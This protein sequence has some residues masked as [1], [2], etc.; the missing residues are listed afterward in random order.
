M[1]KAHSLLWH[2]LWVAPNLLLLGLAFL[3]W[4]RQMH[5]EFPVFFAFCIGSA[6][7]E[8]TV[9]FADVY[10]PITADVWWRI[11]WGALFI[12]GLLK[13][14]LL[15]E[16]IGKILFAY[17]SLAKLA[18]LLTR[19]IGA[20]LVLL[21]VAAAAYAPQDGRFGIVSGAH[22]LEQTIYLT[23]TGLLTFVFIFAAY[24]KLKPPH[25]IFGI[26]V[27]LAFSA[28]V[29]LMTWAVA[30]NGVLQNERRD[31]LDFLNMATYH[32]C[33]LIWFYYLLLPPKVVKK[34]AVSLPEHNLELWNRELERFLQP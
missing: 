1:L 13:F 2:Y 31:I 12:E 30:A 4:R 34:S 9:Y 32:G 21:S 19:G 23:E 27:G 6:L 8:L 28:C 20:T 24:F 29:H 18:K 14:L 16:I 3:L 33:V 11:F 15:G 26:S 10:S 5:R 25:K 7:A 17:A 22:L